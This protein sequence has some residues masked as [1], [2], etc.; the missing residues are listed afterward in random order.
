MRE[1]MVGLA[2]TIIRRRQRRRAHLGAAM[3]GEGAWEILLLLYAQEDE[4]RFK[5]SRLVEASGS[6]PTTGLRWLK[7][8]ESQKLVCR[9]SDPFDARAFYVELT[10]KGR[11]KLDSYFCE[12]LTKAE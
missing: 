4:E 5:V 9:R 7:Y 12:T 6:P 2:K 1:A 8:L 10:D 11:E 3:F